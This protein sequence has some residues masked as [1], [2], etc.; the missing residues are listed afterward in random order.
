MIA[1]LNIPQP[2]S[3]YPI[4]KI[5]K[6]TGLIVLF[7]TK[8]KG[9]CIFGDDYHQIGEYSDAWGEHNFEEYS[10]TVTLKN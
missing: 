4:L 2:K 1:T 3:S 8:E 6:K 7:S 5:Y 9:T 10:G